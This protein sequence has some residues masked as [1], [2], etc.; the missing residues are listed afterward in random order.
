MPATNMMIRHDN[1]EL[2]DSRQEDLVDGRQED[3]VDKKSWSRNYER[4]KK[5]FQNVVLEHCFGTATQ[6]QLAFGRSLHK[7]C[8]IPY[9][10]GLLWGA[11]ALKESSFSILWMLLPLIVLGFG[12]K[13]TQKLLARC[14]EL[15]L[16][17]DLERCWIDV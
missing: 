13:V 11:L 4:R 3:S 15:M 9:M 6:G 10:L 12:R 14:L 16:V 1:V 8:C 2:V 7:S 17:S 5:L